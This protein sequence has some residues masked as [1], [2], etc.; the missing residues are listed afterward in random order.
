MKFK[1]LLLREEPRQ[2]GLVARYR[3]VIGLFW[4]QVGQRIALL[5]YSGNGFLSISGAQV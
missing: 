4:A 3:F 2:G 1:E 5:K